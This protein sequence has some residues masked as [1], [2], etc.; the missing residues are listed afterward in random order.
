LA[1]IL[2]ASSAT[3]AEREI[4]LAIILVLAE[5]ATNHPTE[6]GVCIAPE[7]QFNC[8]LSVLIRVLTKY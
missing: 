7:N 1:N 5:A 4:F 2:V 6:P 8:L 3:S